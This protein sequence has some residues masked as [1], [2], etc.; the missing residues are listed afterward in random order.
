M[1][2]TILR[3]GAG[4]SPL[5]SMDE[6]PAFALDDAL[7]AV[8]AGG[9]DAVVIDLA[10]DGTDTSDAV[11]EI[12]SVDDDLPIIIRTSLA[13]A[14]AATGALEQGAA[15]LLLDDEDEDAEVLLRHVIRTVHHHRDRRDSHDLLDGH[16]RL[17]GA[18]CGAVLRD[19]LDGAVAR[20]QRRREL[21]ALVVVDIDHLDHIGATGPAARDE[22]LRTTAHR[23][24]GAL[25]ATD[26]LGRFGGAELLLLL[27]NVGTRSDARRAA[28]RCL[29]SARGSLLLGPTMVEP[30]CSAGVAMFP[31]H[32]E[33]AE[34]LLQVALDSLADGRLMGPG[35]LVVA[36]HPDAAGR[37]RAHHVLSP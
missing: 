18:V 3:Y 12:R 17:T 35:S 30:S 28:R 23:L 24:Q 20:A 10:S 4:R 31:D 16:D 29:E 15:D 7:A 11:A 14:G 26:T 19:R 9:F 13:G 25:R 34:T 36:S 5:G 37:L 8:R 32:A 27:E 1:G 22:L 33:T 2:L 6:V 21:L